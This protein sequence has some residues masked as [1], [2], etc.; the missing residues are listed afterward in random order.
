MASAPLVGEGGVPG[1]SAPWADP[2]WRE[3]IPV[4]HGS[5]EF[6]KNPSHNIQLSAEKVGVGRSR[7][8]VRLYFQSE[9]IVL[10]RPLQLSSADADSK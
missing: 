7:I 4:M 9:D 1:T 5:F 3:L 2:P 10:K 6:T 8:P